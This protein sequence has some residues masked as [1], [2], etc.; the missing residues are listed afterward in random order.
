[1]HERRTSPGDWPSPGPTAMT[2]ALSSST[3]SSA[4]AV[5]R[6][7]R[8]LVER[9]GHVLRRQRGDDRQARAR[10]RDRHEAGAGP[11]RAIAARCAAPVLPERAGDDQH[12]AEVALVRI[13]RARPDEL[14]HALAR[15]QLEVRPLDARR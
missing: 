5:D 15:Q 6:A 13:G 7:R 3:R 9:L 4:A 10:R 14:A 11:Q 2:S 1:M 8:R 12:A